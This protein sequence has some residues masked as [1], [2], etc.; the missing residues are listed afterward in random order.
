MTTLAVQFNEII[1]CDLHTRYQVVA[2]I[3]AE[4]GEIRMR[5]LEHES[6][7]VR[8]SYAGWPRGTPTSPRPW[9]GRRE[10]TVAIVKLPQLG[11]P[12]LLQ[13]LQGRPSAE[14]LAGGG[15]IGKTLG[16]EEFHAATYT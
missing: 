14:K 9:R 10:P 16:G 1:G 7:E 3:E 6:N 5:R 8:T 15:L 4:T 11:S 12:G 13:G 2:W